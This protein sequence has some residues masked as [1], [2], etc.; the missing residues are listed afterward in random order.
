MFCVELKFTTPYGIS[1]LDVHDKHAC[2]FG[3]TAA[4]CS[5]KYQNFLAVEIDFSEEL[6]D[7][8]ED[9]PSYMYPDALIERNT[10]IRMKGY[11]VHD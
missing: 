9:C 2:V 6:F 1:W 8:C 10:M 4:K 7:E 11:V 3:N 5:V